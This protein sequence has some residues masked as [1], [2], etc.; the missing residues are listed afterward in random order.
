MATDPLGRAAHSRV[1]VSGSLQL[2]LDLLAHLGLNL[3]R[4][5]A[6]ETFSFLLQGGEPL[7]EAGD[8]FHDSLKVDMVLECN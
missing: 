3:V 4:T 1:A 8:L 7:L 6:E 2:R 5:A